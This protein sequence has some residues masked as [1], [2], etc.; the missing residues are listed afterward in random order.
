VNQLINALLN[1]LKT[2]D[3]NCEES[4][5]SE[6]T[7]FHR[8]TRYENGRLNIP[9]LQAVGQVWIAMIKEKESL[10]AR[11]LEGLLSSL[12]HIDDTD[13]T[14]IFKCVS[15]IFLESQYIDRLTSF[16]DGVIRT[17][18]SYGLTSTESRFG[19]FV[20]DGAYRAAVMNA[21]RAAL[22][23]IESSTKIF[24]SNRSV[25]MGFAS[26]L[27]DKVTIVKRNG[28][29]HENIAASVQ[30]EKIFIQRAD[31]L[32]ESGDHISR[33]MSNGGQ[34]TFTVIDPGFHEE[35]H[36]IPAG[37][38]MRVKKLGLPDA[39]ARS[40]Q[41]TTN[42]NYYDMS[43]ENPRV[44]NNSVDNSTN[45]VN[46]SNALGKIAELRQAIELSVSIDKRKSALEVVDAIETE[47]KN[48]TPKKSVVMALLD[49]LPSITN[50][51]TLISS[52]LESL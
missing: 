35:F 2:I 18:L 39:T 44:N 4:A 27:A 30:T 19:H 10:I 51:G 11:E 22:G 14:V 20:E 36:G 29:R 42:N 48:G 47:F 24:I 6:I 12:A 23:N 21:I 37:Y 52:I 41:I 3:K 38:Q 26:L 13:L 46:K 16:K 8:L 28:D 40:Q 15:E 31:I 43:G 33:N 50:I 5:S 32:I 9:S 17:A 45:T 1:K 7:K 49:A 34:E 25:N